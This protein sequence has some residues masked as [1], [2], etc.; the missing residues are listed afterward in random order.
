M[1]KTK[2]SKKRNRDGNNLQPPNRT[3]AGADSHIPAKQKEKT[4]QD[5]EVGD[6]IGVSRGLGLIKVTL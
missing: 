6:Q 2:E 3:I 4:A 1:S 5:G